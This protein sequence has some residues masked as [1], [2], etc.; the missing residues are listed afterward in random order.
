ML[1]DILSTPP[2]KVSRII[3][4]TPYHELGYYELVNGY[5]TPGCIELCFGSIEYNNHSK[6]NSLR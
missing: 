1:C 2:H 4:M 6:Q 5:Y 3:W